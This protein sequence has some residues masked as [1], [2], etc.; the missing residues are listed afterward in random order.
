[1]SDEAFNFSFGWN[2]FGQVGTSA[3]QDTQQVNEPE[4]LELST[5]DM[6]AADDFEMPSEWQESSSVDNEGNRLVG[7]DSRQPYTSP[8]DIVDVATGQFH[9]AAVDAGGRVWTWGNG[10]DGQ[11]GHAYKHEPSYGN[12]FEDKPNDGFQ[13]L[14]RLADAEERVPRC[15]RLP[16]IRFQYIACGTSHTLAL[17]RAGKIYAWGS[18]LKG[19]LGIDAH[20]TV[21]NE[22]GIVSRPELISMPLNSSYR[23]LSV[24]AGGEFS[25]ALVVATHD[26][27]ESIKFHNNT[28]VVEKCNTDPLS[29]VSQCHSNQTTASKQNLLTWGSNEFGQL[30]R[31]PV[32]TCPWTHVLAFAE[33]QDPSQ[34]SCGQDHVI[35]ITSNGLLYAT[36][37]GDS[38]QLGTGKRRSV[39]RFTRLETPLLKGY[40]PFCKVSAGVSS[41]AAVAYNSQLYV[42]GDNSCY[43]LGLGDNNIRLEPTPTEI[44]G[45]ADIGVGDE[46][47]VCVIA[48][49]A[50]QAKL[51]S[52]G[53]SGGGRLGIGDVPFILSTKAAVTIQCAVRQF[54]SRIH[55]KAK[56]LAV[57][58]I[59]VDSIVE[60][61][62]RESKKLEIVDNVL[63]SDHTHLEKHDGN[64]SQD[65]RD[66]EE[67]P[68]ILSSD[69]EVGGSTRDDELTEIKLD[70]TTYQISST[71]SEINS[72]SEVGSFSSK[73]PN[74]E[75]QRA[76]KAPTGSELVPSFYLQIYSCFTDD[77]WPPVQNFKEVGIPDE[78]WHSVLRL[79][80]LSVGGCHVLG[81][82]WLTLRD[83]A[84]SV[85]SCSPDTNGPG[86]YDSIE[87]Q[88]CR[89]QRCNVSFPEPL[90]RLHEMI[91]KLVDDEEVEVTEVT[92]TEMTSLD[93]LA[94][95]LESEEENRSVS[96]DGDVSIEPN[97]DVSPEK[98][99]QETSQEIIDFESPLVPVMKTIR[100]RVGGGWKNILIPDT[101]NSTITAPNSKTPAAG[102]AIGA[103]RALRR[104]NGISMGRGA[105]VRPERPLD[106]A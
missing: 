79:R 28:S 49:S 47:C 91:C 86:W 41:S 30:G 40:G 96:R 2:G 68:R 104:E 33:I 70:D 5:N 102:N 60:E 26:E 9:S 99:C 93:N 45:C 78:S 36:G 51:L 39:A 73:E 67:R 76:L 85:A 14:K 34:V 46:F 62:I 103:A 97:F 63:I 84:E 38:G 50:Q 22:V 106:R 81:C 95:T 52:V 18:N 11:L 64:I 19:Q 4:R 31:I 25:T 8:Y 7:K 57:V 20:S 69:G 100:K 87:F 54:L 101:S 94:P 27:T 82:G 72:D 17:T 55:I 77:T 59:V 29:E 65:T 15:L 88:P 90:I 12:L 66:Q 23:V 92:G 56:R 89:N 37:R 32:P 6:D 83:D 48:D 53:H 80:K 35:A 43:Q 105:E 74:Q 75:K 98:N 1:M 10:R 3:K 24:A 21:V 44:M 61:V 13:D 16:G 42:W 71:D 58:G